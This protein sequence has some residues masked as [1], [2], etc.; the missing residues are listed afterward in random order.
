[1]REK[2]LYS[3]RHI[4]MLALLSCFLWASAV[5]PIKIALRYAGPLETAG[6][7]FTLSGLLLLPFCGGL[8]K[9]LFHLRKN[10][11]NIFV[12]SLFQTFG[13]YGLFFSGVNLVPGPL[14]AIMVGSSPLITAIVAHFYTKNDKMT[15]LYSVR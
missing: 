8:K 2:D 13:L 10:V 3:K 15:L 7:R 12:L 9:Y 1:M 4:I 14:A 11:K 5:V 6:L